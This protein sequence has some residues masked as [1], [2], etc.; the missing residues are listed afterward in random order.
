MSK[1]QYVDCEFKATYGIYYLTEDGERQWGAFCNKHG[2]E[3]LDVNAERIL[4]GYAEMEKR[5]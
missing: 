4:R 3:L 2:K 1:C 5:P